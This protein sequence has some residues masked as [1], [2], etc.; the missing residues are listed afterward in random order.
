[1]ILVYGN[2]YIKN[3]EEWN[4]EKPDDKDMLTTT[5]DFLNAYDEAEKTPDDWYDSLF[6]KI[7]EQKEELLE[8]LLMEQR[9]QA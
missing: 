6:W 5:L 3:R 9:E 7:E 2:K 1:M 4:K 8:D